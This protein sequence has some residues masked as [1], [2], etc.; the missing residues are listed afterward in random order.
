MN[1]YEVYGIK[2]PGSRPT[3]IAT[4]A[5]TDGLSRTAEQGAVTH[6]RATNAKGEYWKVIVAYNGRTVRVWHEGNR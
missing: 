6:A 3:L 4:Y 5:C 1:K 2:T